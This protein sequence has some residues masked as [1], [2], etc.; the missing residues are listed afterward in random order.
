MEPVDVD[1]TVCMH[2]FTYVSTGVR[3]GIVF[4]ILEQWM[5]MWLYFVTSRAR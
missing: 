3:P 4:P 1:G 2:K 5:L